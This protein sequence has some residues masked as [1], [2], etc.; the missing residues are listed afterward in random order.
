M[1]NRKEDDE[2]NAFKKFCEIVLNQKIIIIILVEKYSH[3]Y[4]QESKG[5]QNGQSRFASGTIP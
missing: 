3:K 2:E 5:P 1:Y 4:K